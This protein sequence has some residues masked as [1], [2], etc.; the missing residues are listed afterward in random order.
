MKTKLIDMFAQF[1]SLKVVAAE[2]SDKYIQAM[3]QAVQQRNQ[4]ESKLGIVSPSRGVG[5][6]SWFLG[7][8]IELDVLG[9]FKGTWNSR[10]DLEDKFRGE[11]L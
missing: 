1:R 11:N 9:N 3:D 10:Q 4:T 5:Y 2:D 8:Q 6:A 7:Q